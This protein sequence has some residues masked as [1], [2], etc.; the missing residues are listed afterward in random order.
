VARA[1]GRYTPAR[2]NRLKELADAEWRK[3]L[4]KRHLEPPSF[5]GR[6]VAAAPVAADHRLLAALGE[7]GLGPEEEPQYPGRFSGRIAPAGDR[8]SGEQDGVALLQGVGVLAELY[9]QRALQ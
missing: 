6:L 8:L 9:F 1:K 4:A 7:R 5:L 2:V 3:L